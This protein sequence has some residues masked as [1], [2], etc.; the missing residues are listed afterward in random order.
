MLPLRRADLLDV[1]YRHLPNKHKV[2]KVG[3][4]VIDCQLRDSGVRVYLEDNTIV[5]G[6]ILVGADGTHSKV[7]QAMEKL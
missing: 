4:E 2:F 1:L 3:A 7:R 6:S 5:E